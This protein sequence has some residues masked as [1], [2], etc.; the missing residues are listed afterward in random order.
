MLFICVVQRDSSRLNVCGWNPK[1]RAFKRKP[2]SSNFLWYYLLCYSRR[3]CLPQ[4]PSHNIGH[5]RRQ[6]AKQ[7]LMSWPL[8]S[9]S[10]TTFHAMR[11]E[12]L[13]LITQTK[14]T[15]HYFPVVRFIVLYKVA[16]T[17]E[18]V[19]EI[20][21]C[22][23]SNE[24]YWAVLSCGAVYYPVQG[25]SNFWVCGWNSKVWP[26]TWK[27]LSTTFVWC[28]LLYRTKSL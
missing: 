18:S 12:V 9:S 26:F 7:D 27:L 19:G 2:S 3:T 5:F 21:K 1:V 20:L 8:H 11:L 25:G 15:E 13:S 4:W 23:H 10:Q 24:S 28:C 17:F 6:H 16:L 14:A 22:D